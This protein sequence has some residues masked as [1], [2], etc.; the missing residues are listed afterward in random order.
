MRAKESKLIMHAE[1][2]WARYK[3][4]SPGRKFIVTV[5]AIWLIQALPKWT[6]AVTA[7]GELSAQIM[8]M[9]V[10]P[11]AEASVSTP[12]SGPVSDKQQSAGNQLQAG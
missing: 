8:K 1:N 2:A 7:D 5:F 9:F 12:G 10:T 6:A 11:R 3:Q 4:L